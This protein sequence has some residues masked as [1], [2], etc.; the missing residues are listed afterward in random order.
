MIPIRNRHLTLSCPLCKATAT[1]MRCFCQKWLQTFK[2]IPPKETN[3]S[4]TNKLE[5]QIQQ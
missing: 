3:F 4:R 5:N 1:K 2:I